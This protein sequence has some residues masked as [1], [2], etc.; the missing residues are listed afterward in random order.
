MDAGLN[1]C[2]SS[3]VTSSE[4]HYTQ[5]VSVVFFFLSSLLKLSKGAFEALEVSTAGA[6]AREPTV[7]WPTVSVGSLHCCS[8]TEPRAATPTPLW[9]LLS[10]ATTS[11]CLVFSSGRGCGKVPH[12]CA[13]TA[14]FIKRLTS[15]RY[16]MVHLNQGAAGPHSRN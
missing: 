3:S 2:M 8:I 12:H 6:A 11:V 5:Y 14:G 15:S 16:L 1:S 9:L 7:L 10:C 4:L 13:G